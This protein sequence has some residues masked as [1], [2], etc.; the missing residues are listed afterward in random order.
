MFQLERL[1]PRDEY[2]YTF[3][4]DL[5]EWGENEDGE[6]FLAEI[7]YKGEFVFMQDDAPDE[8]SDRWGDGDM[9][10][11]CEW[12]PTSPGIDWLLAGIWENEHGPVACFVT[13]NAG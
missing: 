2:G 1:P 8:L 12:T 3:H 13:P 4:P 5:P 11:A 9:A 6:P 10:A 7:G